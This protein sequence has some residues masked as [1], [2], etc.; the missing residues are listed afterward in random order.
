MPRLKIVIFIKTKMLLM[1][2]DEGVEKIG[3]ILS[4]ATTSFAKCEIYAS[5]ENKVEESMIVVIDSSKSKILAR[6]E[7]IVPYNEFYREGDAFTQARRER[8]RVPTEIARKY[9]IAELELL[10]KLTSRGLSEITAPPEPG[11]EVASIDISRDLKNIFGVDTGEKGYI[12]F[13][14]LYGYKNVPIPLDVEGLTMH[15]A[16]FGS[17]GSGKSY[18]TGYL[19]ELLS[20]IPCGDGKVTALPA[21]VIDAN[22]DYLDYFWYFVKNRSFGAYRNVLRF[23]FD[24]SYAYRRER[25][26]YPDNIKK[27]TI[28]LEEFSPRELAEMIIAFRTGG[29]LNELQVA[30]LEMALRRLKEQYDWSFNDIFLNPTYFDDL[31]NEIDK[32][33]QIDKTIHSQT[34]RAIKSAIEHFR[35]EVVMRYNLLPKEGIATISSEFVKDITDNPQLSIIDFSTGGA[36]GVPLQIKQLVIAYLTKMLY[37]TFTRFKIEGDERYLLLIIE[38][39]QNYCPNPS[40]YPMGYTLTRETLSLIATQGRK[41]GICLCLVTQRPSFVDPIVL[42]MVNTF[43]IHRVSV[44]DVNFVKR[45][46]GGLPHVLESRLVNLGRGYVIITG[47]MNILGF[48]V[49]CEVKDVRKIQPTIGKTNLVEVLSTKS[50]IKD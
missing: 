36:T 30:G 50:V 34:A 40:T 29:T 33:T 46:T 12:W 41:F 16:I 26:E 23:V 49:F 22:G 7:K 17:T 38:E 20:E 48:P 11:D 3:V 2:A 47:Q 9:K 5:A 10:G 25:Y 14:T 39:A 27:I 44:D 4:G 13:G 6:V 45:V 42:S 31:S 24:N 8:M 37:N 1:V 19:L 18:T 15:L 35:S 32:I 28:D 43:F 21:I